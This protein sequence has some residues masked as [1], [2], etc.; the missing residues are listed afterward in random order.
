MKIELIVTDGH[1][2]GYNLVPENRDEQYALN[3][4]RNLYYF[5][6]E[7]NVIRYD[8]YESTPDVNS[9]NRMT[10]IQKKY[11]HLSMKERKQ[12]YPGMTVESINNSNDDGH[13]EKTGPNNL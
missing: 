11:H 6:I 10:F 4:I 9:I 2:V 3:T 1:T 7:E 5:G 12:K 13:Y 8:G